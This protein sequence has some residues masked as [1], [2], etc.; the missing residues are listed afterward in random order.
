MAKNVGFAK[1]MQDKVLKCRTVLQ[2][3]GQLASMH[4]DQ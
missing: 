4:I 1:C 2:N 3:Q